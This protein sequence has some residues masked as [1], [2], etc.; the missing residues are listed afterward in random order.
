MVRIRKRAAWG[1]HGPSAGRF[2]EQSAG[3]HSPFQPAPLSGL[4]PVRR[5]CRAG[6]HGKLETGRGQALGSC[7]LWA[8]YGRESAPWWVG[9]RGPPS[10][11]KVAQS[12][13]WLELSWQEVFAVMQGAGE[14][15]E[16]APRG[17]GVGAC[18]VVMEGSQGSPRVHGERGVPCIAHLQLTLLQRRRG[19]SL[20]V[21]T[22]GPPGC[23][24]SR[25]SIPEKPVSKQGP[26]GR[27]ANLPSEI[28]TGGA[29][30]FLKAREESCLPLSPHHKNQKGP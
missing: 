28:P 8:G 30:S 18:Q 29:V 2:G 3:S 20:M 15:G 1:R 4:A 12:G 19:C 17:A 7:W 22:C 25:W 24:T 27:P 9:S 11:P 13:L 21:R 16:S 5:M 6:N 10:G 23:G 26:A 14:G